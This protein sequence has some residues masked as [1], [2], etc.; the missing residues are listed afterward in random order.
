MSKTPPASNSDNLKFNKRNQV[1]QTKSADDDGLA[2]SKKKQA[3]SSKT[4]AG[5]EAD[6]LRC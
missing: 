1:A 3:A 4:G 6:R 2:F 5:P